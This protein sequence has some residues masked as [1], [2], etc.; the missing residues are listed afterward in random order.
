M[1]RKPYRIPNATPRD[2]RRPHFP[3]PEDIFAA[4]DQIARRHEE[5]VHSPAIDSAIAD[6]SDAK[7]SGDEG[8][9]RTAAKAVVDA[10]AA[11]YRLQGVPVFAHPVLPPQFVKAETGSL[12]GLRADQRK[13]AV[14]ALLDK[15]DQSARPMAAQQ[16][17]AGLR[18]SPELSSRDARGNLNNATTTRLADT[19]RQPEAADSRARMTQT[20]LR[21]QDRAVF[22]T[23][24]PSDGE[25]KFENAAFPLLGFVARERLASAAKSA[26]Y[27]IAADVLVTL[28]AN[29]RKPPEERKLPS[30]ESLLASGASGAASG[31]LDTNLADKWK[32][33]AG[34]AV[35]GSLS[36]DALS[37][38]EFNYWAAIGAGVG[39]GLWEKWGKAKFRSIF[40]DAEASQASGKVV[41]KAIK[42][43]FGAEVDLAGEELKQFMIGFLRAV[44]SQSRDVVDYWEKQFDDWFWQGDEDPFI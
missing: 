23:E 24:P 6:W 39:A 8:A 31:L 44:E 12:N 29:L 7:Q 28:I 22:D 32:W 3:V 27:S 20:I 36:E 19:Y 18:L 43:I 35:L 42:E 26:G 2:H 15:F 4:D 40:G 21:Q 14:S 1:L 25:A 10:T 38:K 11:T 13:T 37:G 9:L 41:S 30:W 16:L 33:E 34:I 17:M 5:D